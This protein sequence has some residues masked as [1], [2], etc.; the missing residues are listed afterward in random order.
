VDETDGGDA[1]KILY[2]SPV[3]NGFQLSLSYTPDGGAQD[4]TNFGGPHLGMAP[5]TSDESRHNF[6]AYLNYSYEGDDWSVAWGGGV[7]LEGKVESAPGP[8]RKKQ[9][10]IQS[11]LNLTF[12]N[13]S[14]GGAFEYFNH[15]FDRTGGGDHRVGE[16]IAKDVWVAGG[17]VAYAFDAWT[18]GAQYSHLDADTGSTPGLSDFTQDR[19][20]ATALYNVGPGIDIEAELGYTWVDSDP[21]GATNADGVEIDNYDAFEFGIGTDLTF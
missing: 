12:G 21:E 1:Q 13:F 11:G 6:A 16:V 10:F 3:F 2:F 9:E 8:D 20:V 4:Q 7:G 17:G 18:I 5:H 15:A 19:V 14:V